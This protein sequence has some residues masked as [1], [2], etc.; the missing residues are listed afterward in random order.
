MAHPPRETGYWEALGRFVETYAELEQSISGALWSF[1]K[2]SPQIAKALFSGTRADAASKYIN[3]ILDSTKA[4]KEIKAEFNYLFSQL[5]HIT[6]IR[7]LIIHHETVSS[8]RGWKISNRRIA[9]DR[10]RLKER[11]ISATIL[12]QMSDDLEKIIAHLTLLVF[13][14]EKSGRIQIEF[15]KNAYAKELAS[16]WLYKPP[17]QQP[18]QR[19]RSQKRPKRQ[20]P[21]SPSQA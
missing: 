7:N 20:R 17:S 14:K 11:P 2:A 21:R 4:K 9:L 8:P 6:D 3:R 16:A 5:G 18:P 13:R 12:G 10:K 19:K 15:V 1:S